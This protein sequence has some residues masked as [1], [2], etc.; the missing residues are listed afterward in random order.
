MLQKLHKQIKKLKET[1]EIFI[2]YMAD[3]WLKC[4][5]RKNKEKFQ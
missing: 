1:K 5:R 4:T 3:K 2:A